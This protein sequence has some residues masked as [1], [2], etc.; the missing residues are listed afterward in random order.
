MRIAKR[1]L[2][3]YLAGIAIL[4]ARIFLLASPPTDLFREPIF[5]IVPAAILLIGLVLGWF[6][7]MIIQYSKWVRSWYV[8]GMNLSFMLF[9]GALVANQVS[10]WQEQLRYGYNIDSISLVHKADDEGY[11]EIVD[12]FEKFQHWYPHSQ[13]MHCT[14]WLSTRMPGDDKDTVE[15]IYYRYWLEKDSTAKKIA[16]LQLKNK[17]FRLIAFDQLPASDTQYVRLYAEYL[18]WRKKGSIL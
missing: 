8:A 5:Y 11:K 6:G 10:N 18:D 17:T 15:F 4:T 12:G 9:L 3:L 1:A 14:G 7:L 13:Y 2:I 16:K